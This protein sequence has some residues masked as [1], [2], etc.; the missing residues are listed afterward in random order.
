MGTKFEIVIPT[1]TFADN[2][3]N[4]LTYVATDTEGVLSSW[5]KF[6]PD[7]KTFYAHP[8]A[9]GDVGAGGTSKAYPVTVTVND[10]YNTSNRF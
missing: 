7:S 1:S 3:N 6:D 2:E 8:K 10:A 9:A 4:K 5:L